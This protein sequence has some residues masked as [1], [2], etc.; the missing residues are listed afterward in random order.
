MSQQRPEN[1][2]GSSLKSVL[3]V[4]VPGLVLAVRVSLDVSVPLPGPTEAWHPPCA[5]RTPIAAAAVQSW[6][7]QKRNTL[8][9]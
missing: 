6:I 7:T 9:G 4:P 3:H 5:A 8:R 1:A 2:H